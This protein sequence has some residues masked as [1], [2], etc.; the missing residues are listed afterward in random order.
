MSYEAPHLRS[1]PRILQ[2]DLVP[3]DLYESAYTTLQGGLVL[4]YHL[5]SF[6]RYGFKQL[7]PL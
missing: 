3:P 6:G 5:Y 1:I 2:V 7:S 4:W